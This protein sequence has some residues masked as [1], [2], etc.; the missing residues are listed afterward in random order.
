MVELKDFE[1]KPIVPGSTVVVAVQRRYQT[2]LKRGVVFRVG[3]GRN[4]RGVKWDRP[5]IGLVTQDGQYMGTYHRP[6][7]MMVVG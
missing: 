7:R 4:R 2:H 6:D 5:S 3:F 1:G